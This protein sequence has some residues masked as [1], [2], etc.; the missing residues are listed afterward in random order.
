MQDANRRGERGDTEAK[1]MRPTQRMSDGM[2]GGRV[3]LSKGTT[4]ASVPAACVWHCFSE[5]TGE[6][7]GTSSCH[8]SK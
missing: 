8:F 4:G 5:K 1:R 2:R 3:S 7:I 6:E